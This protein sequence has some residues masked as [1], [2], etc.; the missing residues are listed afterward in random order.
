MLQ[1][2]ES[3]VATMGS[4][5]DCLVPSL[6]CYFEGSGGF[7]NWGPA[8]KSRLQALK[9]IP[10]P[11]FC[12][13][14]FFLVYFNVRTSYCMLL[15]LCTMTFLLPWTESL[16]C[17]SQL[18]T[19]SPKLSGYSHSRKQGKFPSRFTLNISANHNE[20]VRISDQICKFNLFF[21][22]CDHV[23]MQYD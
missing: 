5:F 17:A 9:V 23:L 22:K 2:F 1:K 14:I 7:E 4:C 3:E 18:K 8:V 11:D 10:T 12:P 6:Q 13:I 16:W 20:V 19:L 21:R 15:L